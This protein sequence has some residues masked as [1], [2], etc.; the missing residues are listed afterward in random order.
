MFTVIFSLILFV[1]FLSIGVPIAFCLGLPIMFFLISD[2]ATSMAM[3]PHRMT[4]SLFSYVLIALP[5]F[6]LAGRM[7]NSSGV[8]N[9]LLRLA[10]AFVGRFPGG[11]AYANV[12]ASSFFASMSGTAVGDAG[13]LGQVELEMMKKAGYRT[14]FAAGITAASSALGPIIPPSVAMVLYGA[15]AGLSIGDM[16]IAGIIPGILLVVSLLLTV[17]VK[18]N[19]TK[20][21]RAWPKEKVPFSEVLAAIKSGILP[22]MTPLII[23]GGIVSGIVT[24]T[25]AAIAAID[26]ALLLGLIYREISFKSLWK[27]LEETVVMAGV[28]VFIIAIAG[29]FTWV[30]TREG[31]PQLISTLLEPL[32]ASGSPTAGLLIIAFF[33]LLIGLFL[34]STPAIILVTP[35]FLPVV[36]SLGIDPV[37]FG[38]VLILSLTTGIITPPYGMCLFVMSEVAGIPIKDTTAQ[39]IKYLPAMYLAILL[40]CI[41]PQISLFIPDLLTSH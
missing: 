5:A 14:D 20:E 16:F 38:I 17:W 12:L 22:M 27:T 34:D 24:P 15:T 4:G 36:E 26:Y 32:V 30:L 35:I 28:F 40:I 2:P 37:H 21:G 6:L 31:L 10:T 19:F 39:S 23:V 9:R 25:E 7:M 33:L 8:T 29:F 18:A 13:G 3:I 41:F 1:I 11:L